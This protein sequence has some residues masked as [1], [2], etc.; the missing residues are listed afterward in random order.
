[1]VCMLNTTKR[2][3]HASLAGNNFQ[4]KEDKCYEIWELNHSI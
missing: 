4:G 3:L 2:K 1:M